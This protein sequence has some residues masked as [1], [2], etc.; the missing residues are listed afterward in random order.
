MY[1]VTD[2]FY[3]NEIASKKGGLTPDKPWLLFFVY[4][5]FNTKSEAHLRDLDFFMN[6]LWIAKHEVLGDYNFGWIDIWDEGENL[7]ETFDVE[8]AFTLLMLKDGKYYEMP[9]YPE[10]SWNANDV[11]EFLDYKHADVVGMPMRP[12]VDGIW[13]Y[14]EYVAKYLA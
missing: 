14:R 1:R 12:R 9:F 5:R 4:D 6:L 3:D 7:R 2:Y 10:I 13:L 8:S 11:V